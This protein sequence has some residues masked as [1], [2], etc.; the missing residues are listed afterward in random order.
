MARFGLV[1][2]PDRGAFGREGITREGGDKEEREHWLRLHPEPWTT[3]D[4]EAYHERFSGAIERWLD[5]GYGKCVLR[6]RD[7]AETVAGSLRHFDGER[8]ALL[9]FVVMPNHV[10]ALFTQHPE[11][12]LEMLLRSWK[13]FTTRRLNELLD[14]SGNLWQ[15]DYF[16]RLV[17]DETHFR[18][19][20]RY[21]RRNPEKAGRRSGEFV[22]YEDELAKAIA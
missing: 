8:L 14:R 12:P 20:V 18:N 4:E 22:L 11:W 10:H 7:C 19:C 17:R 2:L 3:A 21:V 15:R 13:S 9:S 16:D 1:T 5:A 6:Y